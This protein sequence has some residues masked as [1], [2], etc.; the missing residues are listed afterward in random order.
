M[1]LR[2][3][4]SS[5]VPVAAPAVATAPPAPSATARAGGCSGR[6]PG[7]RSRRRLSTPTAASR[8]REDVAPSQTAGPSTRR[9]SAAWRRRW[10]SSRRTGCTAT[11]PRGS[12]PWAPSRW[13]IRP[14]TSRASCRR[15]RPSSRPGSRLR[16]SASTSRVRRC[17]RR[18]RSS[19]PSTP[20]RSP[21]RSS[22]SPTTPSASGSARRS[23][24]VA[25]GSRSTPEERRALLHRLSQAEGFEQYLRRSFLG[26][27]QFSLEGL[28]SLV[29]MLDETI[30]L[31]AAGGAHEVVIGMAHRG[32]LNALVHTVGRSYQSILR[33]FEGERSIDALVVDPEGGT[34]DVKYHLPASGT[35]R[36]RR[37]A[38]STSR[39]SPI[40]ATSRQ[41]TPSSRGGRGPSRP[42]ARPVR[43]ST[44]P[45]LRCPC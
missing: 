16:C 32:R 33:E 21:T 28:E 4:R 8:T 6:A 11:S 12:T 30:S 15:S 35:K 45:R 20:A 29:P 13:A 25:S 22:T 34:G 3:R 2:R 36:H 19:G 24:R 5:A 27:K 44:T 43:A 23:S 39:S 40:R 42:T 1:P 37:R 18:F 17:S 9:S 10:R 26:Q 14:S 31:A 41:P 38:R 7:R